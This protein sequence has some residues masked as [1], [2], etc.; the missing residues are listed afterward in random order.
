MTKP[1]PNS[2]ILRIN[3]YKQ[4]KSN[5]EG[6]KKPLKLS[7][8][9][10][11]HGPCE[12]A[13]NAFIK[14]ASSLNRY[15]DGSQTELREAI[16]ETFKLNVNKIMCGNGSEELIQLVVRAYLSQGDE[17][18]LSENGFIM[19]NIHCL[20]QGA[21]LVIA[22]EKNHKVDVDALLKRV[23][24][25][26]KFCTIANPNNPTGTFISEEEM[27]RL[28]AGLPKDCIFL[29]DNAYSEYVDNED[30]SD[31]ISLVEEFDNVIMTRT[32]S[33]IY[34]LS[35]L[36]IGWM[37]SSQEVHD[38]IQ[39][40]RTPFNANS[41]AMAAATAAV[42][43]IDYVAKIK[44]LN[45]VSLNYVTQKL[46]ELGIEVVPSVANFYLL[47]FTN[48]AQKS[49]TEAA[50]FLQSKGIIPRPAGNDSSFL[51]I[52]VGLENENQA[53]IDVLTDYMQQ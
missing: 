48:V 35:A 49:A 31:G 18:L 3:A 13:V 21:E 23:T 40:I 17:A 37:Y 19:S 27:R 24:E 7:S 4:G 36:R 20:A 47:D 42:K 33:K 5:I 39:R 38:Y 41:A 1:K 14:S 29:I 25:K 45:R 15:P 9:E 30:F 11:S 44:K 43:S 12:E 52:T 28:H 6:V 22:P 32:F 34:G 10:S 53:V 51:R 8:N 26:T 16:A 2:S 46:T 50:K